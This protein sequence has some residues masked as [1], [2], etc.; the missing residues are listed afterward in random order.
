MKYWYKGRIFEILSEV[1]L[2]IFSISFISAIGSG[3]LYY[4]HERVTWRRKLKHRGKGVRIHSNTSIR[5]AENISMGDN[6]RITMGCCI[7]PER[8]SKIV[9]GNDVIV[10][11]GVK[12]FTANHN[13]ERNGIPMVYQPRVESDIRI[14]N[15]V[16]IG[17]NSVITSGVTIGDGAVIAAG[18]VVT[19]D[20]LE[21]SVVGG[22]PAKFIK[23]RS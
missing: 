8:N 15:D 7:W 6:V 14:G 20:V 9:F 2:G 19:K 1:L 13:M 17:A 18:S 11:P 10:G 16:W 22:V 4:I 3:L 21:Y 23:F 5:N 12:M